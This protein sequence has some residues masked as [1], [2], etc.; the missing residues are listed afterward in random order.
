[1]L[2]GAL[3]TACLV[4]GQGWGTGG[5]SGASGVVSASTGGDGNS[6]VN[7]PT[8]EIPRAAV[9]PVG[10]GWAGAW[11]TAQQRLPAHEVR[12][13]TFR[14]IVRPTVGGTALRIRL[15]N[16]FGSAPLRLRAAAVGVPAGRSSAGLRPGTS[17]PVR[18]G[19]RDSLVLAPG[20]RA[21]SDP[22]PL[23]VDPER[24]LAVDMEIDRGTADSGHAR[25]V[26]V[27]WSGAGSLSGVT[28]G[29]DFTEQAE[30][31]YWLEGVDVR[32]GR[33]AGSVVVVGD[34]LTDGTWTTMGADRRWPDL[35]A[36]RLRK[37]VRGPTGVLNAGIGGNR[38]T[39]DNPVCVTPSASGLRRLDRDA[40]SR[41]D[42]RVMI[43]A[44][45][46]NDV[47]AGVPAQDLVAGLRAMVEQAHARGLRVLVATL[48]PYGCDTGC[49]PPE[50]ERARQAVNRW[51]RTTTVADGVVDLEAAVRSPRR[52]DRLDPRFDQGDH[53]HL[54]DEGQAAM[55]AAVDL[56]H[57]PA[58]PRTSRAGR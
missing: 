11:Q 32:A 37:G 6:A 31:W 38:V 50:R 54:D 9:E 10:E 46:I 51:I 18:F 34:S 23:R 26:Q 8:P 13:R 20:E 36:A 19:G 1:M 40:L 17:H 5:A 49:L 7:C 24:Q 12:D 28:S 3:L 14:Q 52:P 44:L 16:T 29:E 55:A 33:G 48:T 58:P 42:T 25:A 41:S 2:A 47:I 27:S 57:L 4:P 39:G 35:L 22:V 56:T 53:L 30:S 15:A 45:G 21:V 43:L